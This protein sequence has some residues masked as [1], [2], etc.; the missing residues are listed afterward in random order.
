WVNMPVNATSDYNCQFATYVRDHLDP[1]LKVYVE[2]GNELWNGRYGFEWN[3]VDTYAQ[4]NGL[5]HYQ[6]TADLTKNCWD[7]WRQVCAAQTDR[8][9]RVV[10]A[11]LPNPGSFNSEIARLVATSSPDDPNEGFDLLSGAA[12]FA[13]D[14]SSYNAQTTV[15]QIEADL[16][17]SL[18]G[19][20]QPRLQDFMAMVGSWESQLNR[21]IP[22]FM[23]EGGQALL[24]APSA[25]WYSAYT[26]AQTDPG[27]HSV[28]TTWLN[29]LAD[30]GV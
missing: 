4:A 23:Y 17:S 25:S 10:A 12:Y 5:S 22:V 18:N 21:Q 3:W 29:A 30:A 11:Q 19:V 2:Y 26:A 9:L 28:I 15:Q 6:G 13:P 1:G 14:L 20:F 7:V 27:M 24:A 8:M 16:M